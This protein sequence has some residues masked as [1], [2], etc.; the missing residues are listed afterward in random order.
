MLHAHCG[1]SHPCVTIRISEINFAGYKNVLI[2][3]AARCQNQCAE[4]RNLKDVQDKTSKSWQKIDNRKS[5]IENRKL[6]W[7]RQ[8]SNLGPR[9]YESPALTAELQAH[10]PRQFTLPERFSLA[11]PLRTAKKRVFTLAFLKSP[12]TGNR[13]LQK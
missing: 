13:T 4:K 11:G 12:L 9:D 5:T 1:S 2:L 3:R 6:K 10:L 8:D 7:A